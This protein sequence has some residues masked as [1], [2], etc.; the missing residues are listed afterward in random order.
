MTTIPN[1]RVRSA[2]GAAA[3]PDHGQRRRAVTESLLAEIF[4]GR[5]RAGEHL[6]IH[7]LAARHNVSPT[8]IREAL[9]ALEGIGIV[10]I[11]PNRGAVVRSVTATDVTEICQVRRA[12][13]CEATR[14]A[15]G[16][17]E[18]IKLETFADEFRRIQTRRR[19]SKSFIE[20]A[21]TLDS[22]LH[23]L[24]I[25][26]C[27]NRFLSQEIGRLKLLF[28]AFRDVAWEHNRANNDHLRFIEEAREHLAI[29]E[30][31][32][33]G[34]AKAASRAMARH[35]RSGAKYWSRALPA[36]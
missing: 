9:V 24:I 31:L 7:D 11:V 12:L 29:I 25:E 15:C 18:L 35:I 5:V 13:E 6:V 2:N 36:V 1:T 10:D 30:A 33:A 26:S 16:R 20:K 17:L 4:Q 3:R 14:L 27:G 34:D 32:L 21:R 19:H 28:R 22:G 23:D 8:P